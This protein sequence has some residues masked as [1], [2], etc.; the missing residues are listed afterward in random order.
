M[1]VR[2]AAATAWSL[3]LKH[4]LQA[5]PHIA[6]RLAQDACEPLTPTR[7]RAWLPPE[8]LG[9][10]AL[11]KTQLRQWRQRVFQTLIIRD[12]QYGATLGEITEAMSTLADEAVNRA[13]RCAMHILVQRHGR[14]RHPNSGT[15]MDMMIIGM[16]KLGG[17]ELNVSSDIDLVMLYAEEGETDGHRPLSH[18]EFFAKVTR[19]MM[20]LLADFDADG[21]VFRTDLRLRPDGDGSPL[22]WSLMALEHYL[23]TQGREWER[24]AWLKARPLPARFF[25]DS[26]L[27]QDWQALETLRRPFVYRKYFDFDALAALR[28]LRAQI[29][30]EWRRQATQR[31]H[32]DDCINIKLGEGGIRE[33][34][35]IVQLFQLIRGGRLPALQQRTLLQALPALAA[36]GL[37]PRETS[38]QLQKAYVFLRQVEHRLQYREDAQTHVLPTQEDRL[39]DLAA[40]LGSSL[41]AFRAQLNDYRQF[42]HETFKNVFRLIGLHDEPVAPDMAPPMPSVSEHATQLLESLW[43]NPRIQQLSPK[44]QMRLRQLLPAIQQA[45]ANSAQPDTAA[46]HLVALIETIAKRSAYIA[47]LAEYPDILQRVARLTIASPLASQVLRQHPVLLDSLIDWRNL[48]QPIDIDSAIAQLHRNLDACV[49]PDG[50]PDA[51]RQMNLM[52]D[53]Q[54]ILEFQLLAQD[55]EGAHTVE[56]LA[57]LLS[58]LADALLAESL[59]RAWQLLRQRHPDWPAEPQFAIIAYGKLGGKELGY[60]SDVDLVLVYQDSDPMASERYV[61]LARRF[62]TWV[63]SLTSSGRLYEVDLRLRPDGD[64]GLLAVSIEALQQYQQQNAWLWE[65]QALTRARY[66][67]GCPHI[68]EAFETLREHILQRPRNLDA[69]RNDIVAMRQKMHDGHPNRSHL[70]DIK[71]DKGGMVDIEFITQW[72]VLGYSRQHPEL[73][74][75]LGNIALLQRAG[76]LGLLPATLATTVANAYRD[77]RK[78][79]HEQRLQGQAHSRIE[80]A[81]CQTQQEAVRQLW[82]HCFCRTE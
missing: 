32:L 38:E 75:N 60:Q 65:H 24:Y 36:A 33:I 55:L 45:I 81:L 59:H 48:L 39:A 78:W 46:Q 20:P 43:R 28:D 79:Q 30:Q 34:E 57:D 2:F 13:Y 11:C 27:V 1:P 17:Q 74:R 10:E 16:G 72:L 54:K 73:L 19:R 47:L 5:R 3:Y 61:K 76:E 8:V 80:H 56:A 31:Q 25:D 66:V 6:D 4:H 15:P 62:T 49:L 82:A 9:D 53:T 23:I 63:S 37:L 67:A 70:F 18:H 51:E 14:P 41:A 12:L 26:P 77:Y 7:I 42:V 58:A 52:R 68:G 64:A 40:S 21:F 22:A 44:H 29:H 71:H 69:L 35:F 50:S